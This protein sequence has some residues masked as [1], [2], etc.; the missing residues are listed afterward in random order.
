MSTYNIGS[1]LCLVCARHHQQLCSSR[2]GSAFALNVHFAFDTP[3]C[4][5]RE[6]EFHHPTKDTEQWKG[7]FKID[8]QATNPARRAEAKAGRRRNSPLS[9]C[10]DD[11][12]QLTLEKR[13]KDDFASQFTPAR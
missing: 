3:S 4:T 13:L 1:P 12:F 11:D 6:C 8:I 10:H 7:K 5:Q 2:L 9:E